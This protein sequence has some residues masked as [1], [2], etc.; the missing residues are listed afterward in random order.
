MQRLVE[1]LFAVACCAVGI[2]PCDKQHVVAIVDRVLPIDPSLTAPIQ[3]HERTTK[4]PCTFAARMRITASL[5][6]TTA[7]TPV[8][9]QRFGKTY[10]QVLQ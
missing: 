2:G 4:W 9:P 1:A 3:E 6:A 5:R 8:W 7:L 10:S